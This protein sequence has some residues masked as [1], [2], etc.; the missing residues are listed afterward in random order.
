MSKKRKTLL[1]FGLLLIA[2]GVGYLSYTVVSGIR[3]R[4]D[5]ETLHSIAF[6]DTTA[7]ATE[8]SST[9]PPPPTASVET[10]PVTESETEAAA[11]TETKEPYVSPIDFEALWELNPDIYAWIEIVDTD[12]AYPVLQHP[13][14]NNYYLNHTPEGRSGFPGSIYTF[15]V[16]AKD[17]SDFNT[18]IYGHRMNNGTMFS[19]LH[20]YRDESYLK[21][22]RIIKIYLPDRE[23]T[24]TVFAAV[25]YDD[26]LITSYYD[27]SD[28]DSCGAFLESIYGNRDLNS[29]ILAEPPVTVEDRIITLSTCIKGQEQNRYLVVAVLTDEIT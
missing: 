1:V 14:D 29:H 27:F 21:E 15:N 26:R 20:F 23:L 19:N 11:T 18:L 3:A 12:I 2:L 4:Q 16:N 10:V 17:F 9:A 22:H 13:T 28:P 25:V 24:Y 7:T 6:Q 5:A 8:A